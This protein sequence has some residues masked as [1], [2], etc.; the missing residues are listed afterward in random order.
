MTENTTPIERDDMLCGISKGD[1]IIWDGRTEPLTVFKTTPAYLGV[2]GPNGAKYAL[3]P[4]PDDKCRLHHRQKRISG[5][6]N[7]SE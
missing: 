7:L 6:E 5:L 2:E 3:F 1:Q 4:G